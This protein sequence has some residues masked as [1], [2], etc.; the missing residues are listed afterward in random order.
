[1]EISLSHELSDSLHIDLLMWLS[2]RAPGTAQQ[3]ED[4]S[5]RGP[6]GP[7]KHRRK[8]H[9]AVEEGTRDVGGLR[10]TLGSGS[11]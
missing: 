8:G 11:C 9:G 1:M 5:S 2:G 3:M 7:Q 6:A 10:A 4:G